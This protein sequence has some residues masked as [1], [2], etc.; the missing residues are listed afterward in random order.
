MNY[1]LTHNGYIINHKGEIENIK[2]RDYLREFGSDETTTPMGI[3]PRLFV[4]GNT[5]MT[6]G[7]R[8]N[9]L[10]TYTWCD[11]KREANKKLYELWEEYIETSNW[12][13]PRFFKTKK[14]LFEDLSDTYSKDVK[15]IKRYF[16]IRSAQKEKLRQSKIKH[17]NRPLTTIQ[18]M[19]DY[20]QSNKEMVQTTLNELNELKRTE[21][22]ELWQVKANSLVQ[23][24]CNN[25]FRTL[26]WKEVY[27]F[28]KTELI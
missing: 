20:I 24:V 1:R 28:T 9:N 8:G 11:N 17:D 10:S 13:A 23:K 5:I 4:E 6:W 18:M 7:V 27:N 14:E 26:N 2:Y 15:V 16:S 12:D 19:A 3:A 21:N 22:K 25:D